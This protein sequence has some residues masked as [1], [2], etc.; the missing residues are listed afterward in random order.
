MAV[1][2][3]AQVTSAIAGTYVF[4]LSTFAGALQLID[5]Q[6]AKPGRGGESLP[7]PDGR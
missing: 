7:V 1:C 5:A 3:P 4:D 6:F 2:L